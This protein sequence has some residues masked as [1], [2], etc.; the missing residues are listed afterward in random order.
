MKKS[1]AFF[2]TFYAG[3]QE[4]PGTLPGSL[5]SFALLYFIFFMAQLTK[6]RSK[7][8]AKKFSKLP[9]TQNAGMNIL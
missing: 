2:L 3:K 8:C 4:S 6:K 9:E 5:M 7:P 1:I